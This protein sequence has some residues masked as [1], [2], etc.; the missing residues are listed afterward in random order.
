[1]AISSGVRR[2]RAWVEAAGRRWLVIRG[3]AYLEATRESSSFSVSIPM[4]RAERVFADAESLDAKIVVA[5]GFGDRTIITGELDDAQ[6]DYEARTIHLTGR[7]KSAKLHEMKTSEKWTNKKPDEIIK[8]LAQKAGLDADVTSAKVRAGRKWAD[9]YVKL[10]DNVSFAAVIHKMSELMGARWWVD[11]EGKLHVKD[12]ASGT[13]TISYRENGSGPINSDALRIRI[14]KNFVAAKDVEV[15]V[16]SWN[17][18]KKKVIEAEKK[19]SGK[20]GKV[21]YEY[22]IPGLEQDIA[23]QYAKAKAAE[24]VAHEIQLQADCIGDP[25]CA[26][27]MKLQLI[28]TA[29]AQS[30]DIDSV[31]HAFGM[32]GHLMTI[33]AKSAK[34]GRE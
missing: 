15:K 11:A 31:S 32:R 4:R 23:D 9:D 5:S 14:S 2:H 13:Y 6:F 19:I 22:H 12:D 29:F 17:Q 30:L 34:E 3:D 27:G 16:K 25:D 18:K 33:S 10:S 28:G 8:D 21:A 24:H 26:P 7:C 1:M 20:G